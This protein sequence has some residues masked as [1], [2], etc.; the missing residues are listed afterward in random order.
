[1]RLLQLAIAAGLAQAMPQRD[2][3]SAGST[4]PKTGQPYTAA[5]FQATV[6]FKFTTANDVTEGPCKEI[7]LIIARGSL[8][9]G[10]IVRSYP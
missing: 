10:N 8:E 9:P 4:D 3:N 1:M 2:L 5:G 6:D 7:F